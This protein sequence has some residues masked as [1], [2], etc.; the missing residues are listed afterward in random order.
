M[1]KTTTKTDVKTIYIS[2]HDGGGWGE[3]CITVFFATC[4]THESILDFVFK[5]FEIAFVCLGIK[6][7]QAKRSAANS[8][9]NTLSK[10]RSR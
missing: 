3:S 1:K 5:A 4:S 10:M 7:T 6:C 2:A 8:T 9:R